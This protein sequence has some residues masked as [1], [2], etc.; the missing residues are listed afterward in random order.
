MTRVKLGIQYQGMGLYGWQ[1]QAGLATVEGHLQGAWEALTDGLEPGLTFHVAGRTDAGVHAWGQVAH[2]DTAW[3]HAETLVKVRDGLNRFLPPEVRIVRVAV[4]DDG[5][6]ARFGA[7][8]R[9]YAYLLYNKHSLRPDLIGRVG[10]VRLG[11]DGTP[12]DFMRM[13]QA[14]Q[15]LPLGP[16]DYSAFRDADCQSKRPVCNLI[17]RELIDMGD[18][19]LRLNIRADH[20]L[21]HMVRNIVGTLIAVGRGERPVTELADVLASR[22][23]RRAGI[24]FTPDGLYLT[25]VRYLDHWEGVVLGD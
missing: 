3:K 6:H 2:I 17:W 4:V 16:N 11:R 15:A 22:D 23:R 18:G 20:F 9:A 14:L 8:E 19:M 5:F 24:T 21:H 13:W 7:V 12:L 25:D 10:H 1:A